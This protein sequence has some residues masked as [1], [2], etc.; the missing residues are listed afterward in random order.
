[1]ERRVRRVNKSSLFNPLDSHVCVYSMYVLA[2]LILAPMGFRCRV[3]QNLVHGSE[4]QYVGKLV[5]SQT[6]RE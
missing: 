3:D 4:I 1:M 6:H 2:L 5:S